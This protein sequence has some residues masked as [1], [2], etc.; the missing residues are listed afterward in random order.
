MILVVLLVLLSPR[1]L[2]VALLSIG[3]VIVLAP[4][5][6]EVIKVDQLVVYKFGQVIE[7]VKGVSAGSDSFDTAHSAYTRVDEFANVALEYAEKPW[8]IVFGKGF[9]GSIAHHT[10]SEWS[11]QGDFSTDQVASGSFVRLHT[12]PSLIFLKHG[13]IGL[14]LFVALF[15]F[16]VLHIRKTPW[17]F[18]GIFWFSFYYSSFATLALVGGTA[19]I[20]GIYNVENNSVDRATINHAL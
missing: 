5:A 2:I 7:L 15:S 17:L 3:M 18:I 4:S 12:T 19:L 20:L 8:F 9:G 13:L 14:M 10:L 16:A 11:N 1:R 6:L